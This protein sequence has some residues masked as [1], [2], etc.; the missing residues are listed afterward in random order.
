MQFIQFRTVLNGE[1][2]FLKLESINDDGTLYL[3]KLVPDEERIT[4]PPIGIKNWE[5]WA[6]LGEIKIENIILIT[7]REK[8]T[9]KYGHPIEVSKRKKK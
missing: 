3:S 8:L 9:C 2:V 6:I 7:N 1:S 5:E 4:K